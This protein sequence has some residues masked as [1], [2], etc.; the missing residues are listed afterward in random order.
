MDYHSILSLLNSIFSTLNAKFLKIDIKCFHLNTPMAQSECM[1]LKLS[2]LPDI[3][4]YSTFSKYMGFMMTRVN[5][6][7]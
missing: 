1:R 7:K 6:K 5:K 2:D 4:S 3:I